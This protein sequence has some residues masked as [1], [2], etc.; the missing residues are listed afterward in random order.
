MNMSSVFK[1]MAKLQYYFEYLSVRFMSP[2]NLKY[3]AE[4]SMFNVYA[5]IPPRMDFK[6]IMIIFMFGVFSSVAASFLAGR[7]LLKVSVAEVLRDE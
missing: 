5:R 2:E 4:N 6:E 7:K 3:I 1:A